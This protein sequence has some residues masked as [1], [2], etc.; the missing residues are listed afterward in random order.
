MLIS[1]DYKDNKGGCFILQDFIPDAL[2][3]NKLDS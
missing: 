1:I 2:F 3:K